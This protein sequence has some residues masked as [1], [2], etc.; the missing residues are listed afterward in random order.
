MKSL[1][2]SIWVSEDTD[3]IV[4]C[5]ENP[6]AEIN[7]SCG[8]PKPPVPPYPIDYAIGGNMCKE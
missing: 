2:D 8:G 1:L 4:P 5:F 7:I 6:P 3:V